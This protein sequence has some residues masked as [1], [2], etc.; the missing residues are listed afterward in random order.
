MEYERERSREKMEWLTLPPQGGRS[1]I[2]SLR[3]AS[4][5]GEIR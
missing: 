1:D 2:Y 4:R 3:G 5:L